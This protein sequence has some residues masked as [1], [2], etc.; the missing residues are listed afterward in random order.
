MPA[1]S[2]Q[3]GGVEAGSRRARRRLAAKGPSSLLAGYAGVGAVEELPPVASDQD[4]GSDGE[5]EEDMD[6]VD[7]VHEDMD[8]EQGGGGG[9][10]ATAARQPDAKGASARHE[11][12][13]R[14]QGPQQARQQG[15]QQGASVGTGPKESHAPA[16]AMHPAPAAAAAPMPVQPLP[17]GRGAC[18]L[19][20]GLIQLRP[21]APLPVVTAAPC[22]PAASLTSAVFSSGGGAEAAAGSMGTQC[23]GGAALPDIDCVPCTYPSSLGDAED[24]MQGG[25][26]GAGLSLPDP[27]TGL[28]TGID[29]SCGLVGAPQQQ[30]SE[31]VDGPG[32]GVLTGAQAGGPRVKQQKTLNQLWGRTAGAKG[33]QAQQ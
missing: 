2:S 5:D 11:Q 32:S 24:K 28:A 21:G 9:G 33:R 12:Q 4:F 1:M 23:S 30:L 3:E 29:S 22:A 18:K 8:E 6:D 13:A 19:G 10:G 20:A 14:Q 25:M 17:L 27:R 7:Q 16:H 15:Q 31:H 26:Q